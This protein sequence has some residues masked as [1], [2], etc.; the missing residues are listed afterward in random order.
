MASKI[1][2]DHDALERALD[3]FADEALSKAEQIK[4]R[5]DAMRTR[6]SIAPFVAA[7]RKRKAGKHKGI[8]RYA[9]VAANA[10]STKADEARHNILNK[11]AGG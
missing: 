5:A 10:P 9:V 1:Q 11:A 4:K 3:D 2:W 8:R 6:D 7:L